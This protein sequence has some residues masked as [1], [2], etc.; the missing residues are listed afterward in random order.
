MTIEQL[1]TSGWIIF[2]CISGSKAYGLDLPTSDTDIKGVFVL[3]EDHYL[4]LDYI[5]QIANK[6]N[7]IVYYE[8]GRFI[9]LLH[10]NNPNLLEMTAMPEN[11]ILYK[12]PV[13]DLIRT[14][15]FL[16]KTSRNAFAGYA[17]QQIKKARG[18]NKKILNP[19][20]EARKSILDFCYVTEGQGSRPL[21]LWLRENNLMQEQCGLVNIDHMKDYYALFYDDSGAYE[22]KGIMQKTTANEVLLSSIPKGLKPLT[23]L[24]FNQ[25]GYSTYC[26]DFREYHE[27]VEKRNEHRYENTLEHGKNYDAKNMM[28]TFRLLDMAIEILSEGQVVVR[29][30]NREELLA[31][32]AGKFTYEELIEQ[33]NQ[34]LEQVNKLYE[35]SPLPE[36]SDKKRANKILVEIRKTIWHDRA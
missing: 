16:A 15:D 2:E 11:M 12:H 13:F 19:M 10:K 5:D 4:S 6:T 21:P 32:R 29:R 35:T 14:E 18:L 24:Y 27:W 3:P 26:K 7:D 8:I 23:Y 1:K 34:K 33:A 31:I 20:G 30:P 36:K 9:S 22:F 28:H 25:D 17:V